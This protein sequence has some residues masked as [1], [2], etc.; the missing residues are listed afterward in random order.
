M[1]KKRLFLKKNQQESKYFGFTL[2]ECLLAMFVLSII[3]LLFSAII[4]NAAVT[5][6]YLQN[7]KEKIWQIFLIQVEN[8]LQNCHYEKTET[9]Q[10]RLRNKKNNHVVSIEFKLG[11]IVKV[12]NG[13]YQPLLIGV[14]Q[15]VFKEENKAVEIYVKFENQVNV[16]GKWI[17]TREHE[18][19]T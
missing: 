1:V 10:I 16:Q 7:E 5:T 4:K 19:E 2:I 11:K 14:E 13:G 9:N 8:E 3:C 15:V 18:D 17:V 12:E 6:N